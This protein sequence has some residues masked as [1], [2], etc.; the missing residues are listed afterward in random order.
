MD[1]CRVLLKA[2]QNLSLKPSLFNVLKNDLII[3]DY[4]IHSFLIKFKK[5]NDIESIITNITNNLAVNPWIVSPPEPLVYKTK[6]TDLELTIKIK[7][8]LTHLF[9]KKNMINHFI[10]ALEKNKQEIEVFYD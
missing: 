4:P 5:R 3:N 7:I 9:D 6:I 1:K 10:T 8:R 2:S